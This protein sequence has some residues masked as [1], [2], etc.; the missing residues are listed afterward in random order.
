[1]RSS[2]ERARSFRF[3]WPLGVP[4]ISRSSLSAKSVVSWSAATAQKLENPVHSQPVE[5]DPHWY[6]LRHP[7]RR[8]FHRRVNL[9]NQNFQKE[10]SPTIPDLHT[11]HRLRTDPSLSR[12][13]WNQS[14]HPLTGLNCLRHLEVNLREAHRHHHPDCLHQW[15]RLR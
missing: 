4:E 11:I 15:Y 12:R 13:V 14:H 3:P 2:F 5:K 8:A 6:R 10:R 9:R 7:R 1:K